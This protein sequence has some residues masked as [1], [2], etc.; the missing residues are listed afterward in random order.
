LLAADTYD[1][2]RARVCARERE[3]E[4]ESRCS[5]SESRGLVCPSFADVLVGSERRSGGVPPSRRSENLERAGQSRPMTRVEQRGPV[6]F[7]FMGIAV[8]VILLIT[9]WEYL[10]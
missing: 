8:A 4:R 10:F 6:A 2:L 3:R 7:T 1:M 5:V 9:L